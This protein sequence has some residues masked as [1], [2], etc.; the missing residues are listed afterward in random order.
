MFK[1]GET[2]K[3]PGCGDQFVVDVPE[4]QGDTATCLVCQERMDPQELDL[5]ERYNLHD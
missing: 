5:Q 3:C 4:E 2:L 1:K